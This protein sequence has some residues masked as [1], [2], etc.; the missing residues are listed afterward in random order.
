MS[1][2]TRSLAV[3]L[4]AAAS[5]VLPGSAA[6]AAPPPN[7]HVAN[8][9]IVTSVPFTDTVDTSEATFFGEPGTFFNAGYTVWYSFTPSEFLAVEV[10]TVGT[11]YDTLLEVYVRDPE[12]GELETTTLEHDPMAAL[13]SR[14][15][16]R[17]EPGT[18]YYILAGMCC[19][20]F[21]QAPRP[22]NTLVLNVVQSS[23]PRVDLAYTV[24]RRGLVDRDGVVTFGGTVTCVGADTVHIGLELVQLLGRRFRAFG[25]IGIDIPCG[26]TP[27][28]WSVTIRSETGILFGPGRVQVSS[29]GSS[30]NELFCGEEVLDR[31]AQLRRG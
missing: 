13:E 16:F 3:A 19:H 9:T 11:N 24:D 1:R 25:G 22:G 17:V 2:S 30:C 27:T 20:V 10:N 31:K 23:I 14:I 7:D 26:P 18:T 15:D 21:D 5:L 29:F 28:R 4:L 6:A 12:T 8:A